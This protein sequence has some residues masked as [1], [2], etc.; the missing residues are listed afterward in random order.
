MDKY[1][2]LFEGGGSG[3]QAQIEPSP[4]KAKLSV[5][6]KLVIAGLLCLQVPA[7]AIFYPVAT[8]IILTGVGAPLSMTLW[9]IGTKP[10]SLAMRWKTEWQSGEEWT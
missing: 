1:G 9:A 6:Q 4:P 8:V 10:L 5:G 3:L 2:H 7:S